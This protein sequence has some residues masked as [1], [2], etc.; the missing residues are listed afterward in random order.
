MHFVRTFFALALSSA[1]LTPIMALPRNNDPGEFLPG[2]GDD[3]TSQYA[4]KDSDDLGDPALTKFANLVICKDADLKKCTIVYRMDRGAFNL[5]LSN[6]GASTGPWGGF[7]NDAISSVA[8]TGSVP[9]KCYFY[10]DADCV[11]A[12]PWLAQGPG[13]GKP[14]NFNTI[15][16]RYNDAIS[17]FRC[18]PPGP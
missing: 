16:G 18:G 1:C 15:P 2:P 11:D 8:I 3:V 14:V 13:N 6:R 9:M 10:R 12:Q 4:E 5:C 17:S 7:K